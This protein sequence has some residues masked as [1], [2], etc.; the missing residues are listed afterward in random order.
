MIK[1]VPIDAVRASDYNPRKNDEKRLA[2]AELS[3][4]KLGFLLPIYADENGEILSG[5][6]RHLVATRMGF[7]T[8]PVEYVKAKDL[9]E[10]KVVNILFN[11]AT[12][13]LQKQDTC[14]IIKKRLYSTDVEELGG[15]LPDIEPNSPESF[16]CVH[17]L[18]RMDTV[19]LAKQNHRGFDVHTKQLA[20]ALERSIGSA[21]SIVIGESNNVINGIG[22]LQVAAEAG[23]KVVSCVR[24]RADQESFASSMLNLLSMDFDVK[25]TYADELRK[26]AFRRERTSRAQDADGNETLGDGMFRGIFPKKSGRDMLNFTGEVLATWKKYYGTCI[27]DFGAG[28]LSDTRALRRA[29]ITVS[30]FEPYFVTVGDKVHKQKSLELIGKFLDE[31]EDGRQFSTVFVSSVFNSVPF[32]E[33]RKQIATI[34]AALAY[35]SGKAVCW[36][37]TNKSAQ[38]MQTKHKYASG[39]KMLTFD[40][41]YEPNITLGDISRLPKAQKGHTEEEMRE[42]FAPRFAKIDRLEAQGGYWYL[43]ASGPKLDIPGLAAALDFEFDLPYQDGTRMGMTQRAREAFEHRLGVKLPPSKGDNTNEG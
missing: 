22:R 41:D 8:I 26:N 15:D 21:M 30:A 37:Q 31:I 12:N 14:E 29:G 1:L 28:K 2:L 32:M 7:T 43:E 39:E 27:V 35:P 3:L 6:Q 20:K 5:H 10:R 34:L 24:V 18:R 16:P 38:F 13:D 19:K 11:R 40:L 23:R 42:I 36:C 17:A 9:Q 4:R 25:S 33:D